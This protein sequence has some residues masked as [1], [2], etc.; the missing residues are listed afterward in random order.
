MT[1]DEKLASVT[2]HKRQIGF[3]QL[4]FYALYILM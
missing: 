4:E 1:L 2:P 3:L